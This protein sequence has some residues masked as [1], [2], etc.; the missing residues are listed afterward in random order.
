MVVILTGKLCK[1]DGNAPSPQHPHGESRI[2]CMPL[3][4]VQNEAVNVGSA[5]LRSTSE[6]VLLLCFDEVVLCTLL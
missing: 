6:P 4:S 2:L 3:M 1:D 5:W